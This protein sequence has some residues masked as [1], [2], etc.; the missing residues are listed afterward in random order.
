MTIRGLLIATTIVAL[1]LGPPR[2]FY[3]EEYEST[4]FKPRIWPY[5]ILKQVDHKKKRLDI[6]IYPTQKT[7]IPYSRTIFPF[8]WH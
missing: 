5:S 7:N 2:H 6:A 4:Y 8:W 3:Y 1:W